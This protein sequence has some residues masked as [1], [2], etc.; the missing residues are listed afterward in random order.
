MKGNR[1]IGTGMGLPSRVV[2]NEDL[3]KIVDTTDE[4]ITTRT[5]IKERRI[6]EDHET[7]SDFGAMAERYG[8]GRDRA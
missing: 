3:A 1:I 6:A 5:G 2:T 7:T 4:W 8:D